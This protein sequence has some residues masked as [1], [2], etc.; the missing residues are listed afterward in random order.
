MAPRRTPQTGNDMDAVR[1]Q[2]MIDTGNAMNGSSAD[3]F[4]WLLGSLLVVNGGAVIALL[5]SEDL[6]TAAFGGLNSPGI[7]FGAGLLCAVL[8][9]FFWTIAFALA[10]AEYLR[11]AWDETPLAATEFESLRPKSSTINWFGAALVCVAVSFLF[12]ALGS[13]SMV[14]MPEELAWDKATQAHAEASKRFVAAVD[15][16]VSL[17][18]DRKATPDQV[19][20]ALARANQLRVEA[21]IAAEHSQKALGLEDSPANDSTR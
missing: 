10:S 4:K 20:A 16:Y 6:R 19:Q 7:L 18:K 12:F 2:S 5:G 1:R 9:G 17:S 11:R 8:T 3:I 14:Y 21:D 15:D 13:I